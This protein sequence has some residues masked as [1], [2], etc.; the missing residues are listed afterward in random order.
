MA[1]LLEKELPSKVVASYHR[2]LAMSVQFNLQ[3]ANPGVTGP[4]VSVEIGEYLSHA[5]REAGALPVRTEVRSFVAGGDVKAFLA[6]LYTLLSRPMTYETVEVPHY[7]SLSPDGTPTMKGVTRPARPALGY[8][9][10]AA[11]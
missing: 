1:M 7:E 6:P 5:A 3:N 9:G 2:I 10:A 11:V 8:E 4:L